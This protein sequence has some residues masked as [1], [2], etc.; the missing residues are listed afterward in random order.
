MRCL[1]LVLGSMHQPGRPLDCDNLV[2]EV[3]FDMNREQHVLRALLS[4]IENP[5]IKSKMIWLC[6]PLLEIVITHPSFKSYMEEQ[7]MVQRNVFDS[8]TRLCQCRICI[9]EGG[10]AYQLYNV[11]T[12]VRC[13][14]ASSL[15][16]S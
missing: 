12:G 7:R 5:Y 14:H 8:L 10:V 13:C 1:D 2:Q 4:D 9:V 6:V 16:T 15:S 11:V 3:V